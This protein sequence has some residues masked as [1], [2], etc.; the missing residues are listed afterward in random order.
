MTAPRPSLTD[1]QKL[2]IR[3]RYCRCPGVVEMGIACGKPLP[4]NS[5][6]EFDHIGQRSVT[7]DDTLENYRPLCPSC[8]DQKTNGLG[9]EKRITTAGSD[10]NRRAKIRKAQ[11]RLLAAPGEAKPEPKRKWGSRPFPKGRG[12][13]Q[14][15]RDRRHG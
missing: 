4:A 10:A 15:K 7:G 2:T 13:E 12:F 5:E 9:G 8:H 11:R 1:K 3:A 14:R 6:C